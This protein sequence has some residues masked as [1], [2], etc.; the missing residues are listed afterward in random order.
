[1]LLCYNTYRIEEVSDPLG[2]NETEHDWDTK[3]NISCAL[4]NN[5]GQTD[6]HADC[7]T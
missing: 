3:G 2:N 7:S 5:N 6:G 4:N 1:M